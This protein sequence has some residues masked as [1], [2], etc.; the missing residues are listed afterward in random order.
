VSR[1]ETLEFEVSVV[2]ETEKAIL[3]RTADGDEAWVPK[4]QLVA[5]G[6]DVDGTGDV[7]TI[8]IPRWL[9]EEKGLA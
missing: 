1:Y 5:E 7:G 3:V 9:A 4:S 6:T 2:R 8:A